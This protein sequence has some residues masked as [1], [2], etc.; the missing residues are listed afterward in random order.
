MKYK[1]LSGLTPF[2]ITIFNNNEMYLWDV[3]EIKDINWK[4]EYKYPKTTKGSNTKKVKK[5]VTYLPLDYGIK[6]KY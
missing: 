3:S 1:D 4:I 5:C 6:C 2:Y